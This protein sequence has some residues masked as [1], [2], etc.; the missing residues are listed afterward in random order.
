MHKVETAFVTLGVNKKIL[1][2]LI[3][4]QRNKTAPAWYPF[5][6]LY[7]FGSAILR[8]KGDSSRPFAALTVSGIINV[9]LNLFFVIVCHLGVAGVAI[10]TD[11][12]TAV[13]ALL[14]CMCPHHADSSL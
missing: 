5:L 2:F 9:L 6:M 14:V 8:A 10:A 4:V 1:A 12:S 11:I 13:S 7:D 3:F